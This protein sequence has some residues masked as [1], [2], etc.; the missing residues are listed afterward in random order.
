M[1]FQSETSVFKFLRLLVEEALGSVDE[2]A[3]LN[4]IVSFNIR[5]H[6]S[7]CLTI[8]VLLFIFPKDRD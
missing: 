7:I 1:S 5:R 3:D 2:Y 8:L 4:Y 6:I